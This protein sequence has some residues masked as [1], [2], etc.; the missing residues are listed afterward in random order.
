MNKVADDLNKEKA[1]E[2]APVLEAKEALLSIN[3]T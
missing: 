2:E 3:Q 1:K